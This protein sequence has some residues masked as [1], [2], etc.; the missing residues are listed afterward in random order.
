MV[1]DQEFFLVPRSTPHT[2]A[3]G[4]NEPKGSPVKPIYVR[5]PFKLSD[6]SCGPSEHFPCVRSMLSVSER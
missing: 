4:F 1:D 3:L 2:K 5:T 6:K